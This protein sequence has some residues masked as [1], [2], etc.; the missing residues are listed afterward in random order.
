MA[1]ILFWKATASTSVTCPRWLDAFELGNL[2]LMM[3]EL[4]YSFKSTTQSHQIMSLAWSN[5]RAPFVSI[6]KIDFYEIWWADGSSWG[7]TDQDFYKYSSGGSRQKSS[8]TVDMCWN[9]VHN[10]ANKSELNQIYFNWRSLDST[11]ASWKSN[12]E[13]VLHFH[14]NHVLKIQF[15]TSHF[16][17][18]HTKPPALF[19]FGVRASKGKDEHDVDTF[20]FLLKTRRNFKCERKYIFS[21][22]KV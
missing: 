17:I 9:C 16:P 6:T 5:Q 19:C 18:T 2:K 13:F 20:L 22:S 3:M 7:R 1:V 11:A 10:T 15:T 8:H 14:F 21:E 12:Q 4:F